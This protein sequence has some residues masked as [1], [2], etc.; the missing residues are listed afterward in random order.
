[1][2]QSGL[3][4][5]AAI[6]ALENNVDR[7]AYDHKNAKDFAR[8]IAGLRGLRPHVPAEET[9]TNMVFFH[10]DPAIGTAQSL[11]AHVESRGVRMMA[12]DPQR[13]RAV[14]HRDVDAAG[15]VRAVHEVAAAVSGK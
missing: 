13:I 1:M 2:R 4:A 14:T 8:G 15:I 5:A 3:L 11:C 10:V 9:P 6:F 7:L 12:L